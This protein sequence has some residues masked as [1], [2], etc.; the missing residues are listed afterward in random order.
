MI[1]PT[2]HSVGS[3][4]RRRWARGIGVLAVMITGAAVLAAAGGL[5]ALT[6]LAVS[7]STGSYSGTK[8]TVGTC[9]YCPLIGPAPSFEFAAG[10]WVNVTWFEVHGYGLYLTVAEPSGAMLPCPA[11]EPSGGSCAFVATGGTY[12]LEFHAPV[13]AT[14]SGYSTNYTV[15]YVWP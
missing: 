12:T 10:T 7:S 6:P 1:A 2:R 5:S 4:V 13:P 8:F 14:E 11:G 9:T 15:T 3:G